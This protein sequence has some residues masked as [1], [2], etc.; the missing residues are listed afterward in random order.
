MRFGIRQATFNN[1]KRAE[2]LTLRTNQLDTTGKRYSFEELCLQ[3]S[4]DHLLLVAEF[5]DQ[6]GTSG[7]IGLALIEKTFSGEW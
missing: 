7:K 4:P 3:E 6:Y 2:V 1:L 5:E